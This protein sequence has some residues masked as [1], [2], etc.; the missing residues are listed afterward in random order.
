MKLL[1]LEEYQKPSVHQTIGG[2]PA[3]IEYLMYLECYEFI[4]QLCKEV[5]VQK[6]IM[7]TAFSIFH[8]YLKMHSFTEVDRF[9]L[10]CVCVYLACKI[11]YQ[12]MTLEKI[13]T[14][15]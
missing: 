4:T 11:D 7:G 12:H 15:Y 5:K 9:A 6:S 14:F 8:L 1:T 3:R 13:L 2:V 10:S